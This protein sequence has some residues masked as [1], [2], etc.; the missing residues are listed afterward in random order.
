[1]GPSNYALGDGV[2]PLE[3]NMSGDPE[4]YKQLLLKHNIDAKDYS[5][6]PLSVDEWHYL[7]RTVFLDQ[8]RTI[9]FIPTIHE[10]ASKSRLIEFQKRIKSV[11]TFC[12][13][14]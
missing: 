3:K 6:S 12:C 1:M 9:F 7:T 13:M 11:S 8:R 5:Y 2:D 14:K 4:G 10:T